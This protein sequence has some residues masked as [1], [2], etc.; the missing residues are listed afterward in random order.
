MKNKITKKLAES[1]ADRERLR[2]NK[3]NAGLAMF[4][5][6]KNGNTQEIKVAKANFERIKLLNSTK[7]AKINQDIKRLNFID[8]VLY[9]VRKWLRRFFI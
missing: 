7:G 8:Q 6:L 3:K 9:K 1:K 5:A 4:E 2:Q